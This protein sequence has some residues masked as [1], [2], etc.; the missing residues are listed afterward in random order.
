MFLGHN[1]ETQAAEETDNPTEAEVANETNDNHSSTQETQNV[2]S[3]TA[4]QLNKDDSANNLKD[5]QNQALQQV[6]ALQHLSAEQSSS[7]TNEIK[8]AVSQASVQAVVEKALAADNQAAQQAENENKQPVKEPETV[9]EPK[10][11]LK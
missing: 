8:N 10:M 2:P 1:T 6:S 3:E 11:K 9:E 4:T 7:F 5:V